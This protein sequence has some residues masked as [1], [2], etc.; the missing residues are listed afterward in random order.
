MFGLVRVSTVEKV[1]EEVLPQYLDTRG[2]PLPPPLREVA[3]PSF[4]E[5][6][7]SRLHSFVW[8]LYI[9]R[10]RPR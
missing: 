10:H 6:I 7:P 1:L 4:K 5:T 9:G 8:D 3:E 2:K